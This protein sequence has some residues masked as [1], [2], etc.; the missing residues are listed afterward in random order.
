MAVSAPFAQ[1]LAGGRAQFNARAAEARRRWPAFDTAAF[2]GFLQ[3][4]VDGFVA[5]VAAA[6]P[7]R[8]GS[9]AL[10][11]YDIAL[12]LVGQ[13]L[14]GPQAR[15]PLVDRLWREVL[16]AYARVAAAHPAEVAGMLTNAVVHLGTVEGARPEAWMAAMRSLASRI[17]TPEQ[18]RAVGQVAAWRCGLA[19]F[20]AGA[21]RAADGLPEP[22]ALAALGVPAQSASAAGE[23]AAAPSWAQVRQRLLDDPWWTPDTDGA[24]HPG[25]EFG[26]FAG[27]GG[28]FA[29]PPLV[30]ACPD[31]FLVKSAQRYGLL[32]ADAFGAVLH[33]ATPEDFAQGQTER[34][35]GA[36]AL[37]GNR[38]AIGARTIELD[39]P[40]GDISVTHNAHTVAV[41]SPFTHAIRLLPLQ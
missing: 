22:L 6:A 2:A 36:V 20:R 18:L 15:S 9:V 10:A 8:T 39:L 33:P 7:D 25:I 11:A 35:T 14:A 28:A 1:V 3:D 26:R 17:E 5:A 34:I 19:H 16:P 37:Q 32:V 21:L 23:N 30:R 24:P 4:G 31:G 12:E 40:A 41:T 27:F 29:E 13:G 38:L